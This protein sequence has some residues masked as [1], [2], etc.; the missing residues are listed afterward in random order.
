M[1]IRRVPLVACLGLLAL[2][3]GA[4]MFAGGLASGA[5]SSTVVGANVLT[6]T[7]IDVSGCGGAATAFGV[8]PSATTVVTGADCAIGFG[9]SNAVAQLRTRQLDTLGDAMERTT[10]QSELVQSA[11]VWNSIART[12][13]SAKLFLVGTPAFTTQNAPVAV[14]TDLGATWTTSTLGVVGNAVDASAGSES[15][16]WVGGTFGIRRSNDGGATWSAQTVPAGATNVGGVDAIDD[17]VAWALGGSKMIRTLDGGTTWN[18]VYTFVS[19]QSPMGLDALD[20]NRAI[21]VGVEAPTTTGVVKITT[22]GGATWTD[23]ASNP[24]L[25]AQSWYMDA[26]WTSPNVLWLKSSFGTW[27]STDTGATWTQVR[28]P[29][30]SSRIDARSDTEAAIA[31]TYGG[32]AVTTDGGATWTTRTSAQ[33]GMSQLARSSFATASVIVA[34]GQSEQV[35]RS[36]DTGSTWTAIDPGKP[37]WES[38]ARGTASGNDVWIVGRAGRAGHT[39]DAGASWAWLGTIPGM[40][41]GEDVVVN[42]TIVTAVGSGGVIRTTSDGGA[43]WQAPASGTTQTFNSVASATGDVILAVGGGGVIRRSIDHGASWTTVPS[44][45]GASLVEVSTSDDQVFAIVRSSSKSVLVSTDRGLTWTDR[46][47]TGAGFNLTGVSI[48]ADGSMWVSTGRTQPALAEMWKSV[49]NGVTWTRLADPAGGGSLW[50]PNAQSSNV[51]WVLSEVWIYRTTDGGATWTQISSTRP[52]NQLVR[53]LALDQNRAVG[54][55]PSNVVMRVVPTN[56]LPDVNGTTNTLG[57]GST[58]FGACLR[59]GV[60]LTPTWTDA[61]GTCSS[62]VTAHWNDIP[63]SWDPIA[64]TT[65]TGVSATANLRW[66]M[67][68]GPAQPPGAYIAQVEFGVIAP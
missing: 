7:S 21:A 4:L 52:Q 3:A 46:P 49:D 29:D 64:S 48:A 33:T 67:R 1:R 11:I 45:T 35:V 65:G 13:S 34:A 19:P 20:A 44:G 59:S 61:G 6:S 60:S 55:G 38:A 50:A 54:V 51:A 28:G 63:I 40:S 23:I 9:S 12:P 39:F 22:D 41:T 58:A 14:S 56:S 43:T 32:M 25:P 26:A 53:L 27:R 30:S 16:I 66:G 17:N 42:D 18:S 62:A 36:A 8:V 31:E 24:G 57:S 68:T 5:A 47:V 2:F 37:L 10:N 15:R